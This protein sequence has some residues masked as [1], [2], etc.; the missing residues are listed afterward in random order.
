MNFSPMLAEEAA[1]WNPLP[2]MGQTAQYFQMLPDVH[3]HTIFISMLKCT[4][5]AFVIFVAPGQL[6]C[7][8]R[9]YT[10]TASLGTMMDS[11]F[12]TELLVAGISVTMILWHLEGMTL[13]SDEVDSDGIF[14]LE[15]ILV[16][17]DSSTWVTPMIGTWGGTALINGVVANGVVVE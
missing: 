3:Q 17:G 15:A 7:S 14:L 12:G 16:D 11:K 13:G 9:A 1:F 4:Y 8:G 10:R 6:I 5:L 2:H